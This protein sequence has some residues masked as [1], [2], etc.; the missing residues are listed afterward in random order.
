MVC[1]DILTENIRTDNTIQVYLGNYVV[2][3]WETSSKTECLF[4]LEAAILIDPG[5]GQDDCGC[6]SFSTDPIEFD[7]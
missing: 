4:V 1:D 7:V 6:L 2:S 5:Q 3:E